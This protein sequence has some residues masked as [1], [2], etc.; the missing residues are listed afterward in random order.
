MSK[1][2]I[3]SVRNWEELEKHKNSSPT[4]RITVEDGCAWIE[5]IDGDKSDSDYHYLSRHTF[6]KESYTSYNKI[7]KRCGFNLKIVPH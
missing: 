3:I 4:H 5:S 2:E 7:L 6:Y 1:T